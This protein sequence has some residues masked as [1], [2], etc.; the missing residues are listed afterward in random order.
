VHTID[1]LD[2]DKYLS[3]VDLYSEPCRLLPPPDPA[4]TAVISAGIAAATGLTSN[5]PAWGE[6]G[7]TAPRT[8]WIR[9]SCLHG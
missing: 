4:G 2:V 6:S 9:V 5:R 8:A 3:P 7:L 1:M